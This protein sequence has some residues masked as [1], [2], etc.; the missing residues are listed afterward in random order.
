MKEDFLHYLWRFQKFES[1]QLFTV[2]GELIQVISPGIPTSGSGPDFSNAKIWI[3]ATLWAGNVELH[4]D[5]SSWYHHRHHLDAAY[6]SVILHVV[7]NNDVEVCY[8][9][10]SIMPSLELSKIISE[11]LIKLYQKQFD[12]SPDW[13]PCERIFSNYPKVK[14]KNWIERLYIERLEEKVNLIFNLLEANKNDWEATLFQLLAKNF[15]L[16]VNGNAFLKWAQQI[17]FSVVRKNTHDPIAL[18]ALFFGLSGLLNKEIEEPYYETLKSKYL[19]LKRKHKIPKNITVNVS[20]GRLRPPNFPTIRLSQLA[21]FYNHSPQVFSK[22][23]N[24]QDVKDLNWVLDI[25]VSD[26]WKTHFG[27]EK[28]GKSSSK[29]ISKEFLDLILINSLIPIRFA[30]AKHHGLDEDNLLIQWMEKIPLEKNKY[31]D[32]FI[33]LGGEYNSALESQSLLHLKQYYCD[34]KR[35]LKCALGYHFFKEKPVI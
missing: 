5:A 12:Q 14:W 9:S 27:F 24:A 35:C 6:D 30:H 15:G 31:T 7:W 28:K 26:F 13:I 17:S 21:Q 25:G 23:I 18:E 11:N 29:K 8:P 1:Q 2:N 34:K 4:P 32:R 20:F 33:R 10:G 16:N 22:L 3:G 19:F